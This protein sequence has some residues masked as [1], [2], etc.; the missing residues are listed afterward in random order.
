MRGFS[1][2]F[3][4]TL[5]WPQSPYDLKLF[6]RMVNTNTL[7]TQMSCP[8]KV[9]HQYFVQGTITQTAVLSYKDHRGGKFLKFPLIQHAHVMCVCKFNSLH[10]KQ[11]KFLL[12]LHHHSPYV[13]MNS[14]I[15]IG[16][17]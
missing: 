14:D 16:N 15:N 4:E 7:T 9:F 10:W 12:V 5:K 3:D 1:R 13:L 8:R 11:L 2:L 6:G 17:S